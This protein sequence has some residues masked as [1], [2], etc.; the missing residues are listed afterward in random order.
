M[1]HRVSLREINQHLTRYVKAAEAGERIVITRRGNP[2]VAA[3]PAS[4]RLAMRAVERHGLAFWDAMQWAVAK[5]SGATLL[6]SED[7]QHDRE[8][9]GVRFRNPFLADDP[10][11]G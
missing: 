2:V 9:D 5:Q 6:L 10:F 8:L 1:E 11:A 7:L 4:L 3:T